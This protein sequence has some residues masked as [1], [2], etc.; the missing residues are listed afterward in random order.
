MPLAEAVLVRDGKISLVGTSG[1][2]ASQRSA[3]AELIDLKGRT[4]LP[5][6]I[7]TH[8]H[9][10][11]T[12]LS[13]MGPRL[14][15]LHT[16]PQVLTALAQEAQKQPTIVKA[17][18]LDPYL[19]A[20]GHLLTR[21]ELDRII[22]DKLVYVVRRD[23][24]AVVVNTRT[25]EGLA[26]PPDTHGVERDASTGE[27]TGILR[28]DARRIAGERLTHISADLRVEAIRRATENAVQVGLTTVHALDGGWP[29]GYEDIRALLS[30]APSLPAKIVVYY[31]T[32][33]VGKASELGLP[34]IG[35]CLLVDGS[36]A[37]HTAALTTPYSDLPDTEG[38]LYFSDQELRT[39][40]REAHAAGLQVSMHSIGDRAIQQLLDAYEAVLEETPRA[41]HRHRIEH[42]L[43]AH[44]GQIERASRLG[45]HV[46][47]QPAFLH[48]G[49]ER[50]NVYAERLGPERSGAVNPLRQAMDAGITVAGGSDSFI[51]PMNPLLG[52]H[53]AV[54]DHPPE[55]RLTPRKALEMFTV[56][57]ARIA[58][59][60][61]QK[62]SIRNGKDADLVVLGENP[63]TCPPGSIKDIAVEMTL[64]NG[65]VLKD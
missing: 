47:M 9:L 24:H 1:E 4:L 30:L 3:R 21:W 42:F 15:S 16:L 36:V 38:V 56:N 41:D 58:F 2:V 14:G 59:E 26:L 46:S 37:S 11:S 20:G 32:K 18:G 23:G 54:N 7:D 64:V 19:L 17:S 25:L 29:R 31:Q 27:P 62:G 33:D 28:A 10:I 49:G 39:F 34:R 6:F 61:N 60:E 22:P 44:P 35:G 8:V 13:M 63:L 52:I 45:L 51:T 43:L 40:I 65:V 12:G 50:K 5:G 55:S 53:A 48:F 57:G